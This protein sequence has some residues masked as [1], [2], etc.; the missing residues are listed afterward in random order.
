[1][2]ALTG[3]T[4]DAV[5]RGHAASPCLQGAGGYLRPSAAPQWARALG[6][7]VASPRRQSAA[8]TPCRQLDTALG[9]G[10]RTGAWT[11]DADTECSVA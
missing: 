3:A 7:T 1:M 11:G 9:A 4:L 5:E 8:C 10:L 2:P 6:A